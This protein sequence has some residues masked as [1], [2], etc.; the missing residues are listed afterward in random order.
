MRPP[1]PARRDSRL[2]RPRRGRRLRR[3]VDR[4][5]Q[6]VHAAEPLPLAVGRRSRRRARRSGRSCQLVL[7]QIG[8]R[9]S[10]LRVRVLTVPSGRWR[11]SEISLCEK[12]APV[13]ELDH[14]PLV[15]GQALERRRG[16]AR[17]ASRLGLLGRAASL[18]GSSGGSIGGSGRRR[19]R[20]RS[21]SGRRCRAR[22]PPCPRRVVAR[23]RA[24]DRGERILERV[25]GA[26]AVAEPPQGEPE[27]GR[28][29]AVRS[30]SNASRSPSPTRSISS[31]SVSSPSRTTRCLRLRVRGGKGSLKAQGRNHALGLRMAGRAGLQQPASVDDDRRA[32]DEPAP[33]R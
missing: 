1:P 3:R 12:P 27:H 22:R 18:D 8:E 21:R 32:R 11:N 28:Y 4:E 30:S 33:A 13:R 23:G 2:L 25:L 19:H 16:R 10:A 9:A 20:R 7:E 15:V 5:Q 24:P 26:P 6:L 14:R 29:S 31:P 17:R